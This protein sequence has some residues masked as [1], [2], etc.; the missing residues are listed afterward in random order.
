MI[1]SRSVMKD[2]ENEPRRGEN[3]NKKNKNN[4]CEQHHRRLEIFC[5]FALLRSLNFVRLGTRYITTH[6]L[7][8]FFFI[9]SLNFMRAR[10][11]V[12]FFLSSFG[13]GSCLRWCCNRNIEM[14]YDETSLSSR[15]LLCVRWSSER[16]KEMEKLS[17]V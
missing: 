12:L 11:W 6:K 8:L 9:S 16:K 13:F 14:I 3:E 15:S 7:S 17:L 10:M 1:V 5:S 2:N 4:K